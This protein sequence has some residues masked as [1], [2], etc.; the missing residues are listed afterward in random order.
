MMHILVE[1]MS[2]LTPLSEE[3]KLEIEQSFPIREFEK[4][5]FLLREGQVA[6]AAYYVIE[7]CIREYEIIDGE[8]KTTAFYTEK[9]SAVNFNSLANKVPS[10]KFFVCNESTRLAV[11]DSE[12]EQELYKKYPRFESFCR[13]G[14]EKMLG[15]KQA[16]LGEYISLKPEQRYL[17]LQAERPELINRVP[18]YQIASYIGIKPETLSRI[19]KRLVKN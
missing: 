13:T 7:G 5:S 16:Q 2:E 8:E 1:L 17:K 3:E 6:R 14:M 4:D 11:L 19:R 9:Q 15:E 10:R 18:Q 12:K